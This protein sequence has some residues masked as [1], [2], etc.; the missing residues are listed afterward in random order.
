MAV[1]KKMKILIVDDMRTMVMLISSMLRQM[2]FDNLDDASDGGAA[3]E[4]MKTNKYEMILSDWNME[5]MNGLDFLKSLR[6]DPATQALPFMLITAESKV[7]N[8]IIAK[9]SGATNY[10]VKPFSAATLRDKLTAMLGPF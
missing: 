1:N 9:K 2:G 3:L 4:K 8:V 6:S 7:E 10:I 5:P